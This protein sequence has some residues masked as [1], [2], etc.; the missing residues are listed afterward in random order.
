MII[1]IRCMSCGKMIADKWEYFQRRVNELQSE[2]G[3]DG[4]SIHP[5]QFY[6][7]GKN[8]PKT[9][10]CIALD[11]LELTRWCCRKELLTHVSTIEKH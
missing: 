2:K 1:P 4:K 11:E 6:S 10:E 5:S 7:D 9:A 8:I 3:P